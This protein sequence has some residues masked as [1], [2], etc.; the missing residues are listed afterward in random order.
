MFEEM[1][2]DDTSYLNE[3]LTL[4]GVTKYKLSETPSR[5]KIIIQPST[6]EMKLLHEMQGVR[7]PV[8]VEIDLKHG[9][10]IECLKNGSSRKR[11]KIRLEPYSGKLPDKYDVG[12]FEPVMRVLLG[13]EDICEFDAN[14]QNKEL[15]VKNIE[16][17]TYPILKS[18]EQCGYDIKFNMT[19]EYMIVCANA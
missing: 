11:R 14:V 10:F 16:C 4:F 3:I 2:P 19:K 1:L 17:L 9:L 13:I 7:T 5:F 18:I 6:F 8:G 15:I 12:E